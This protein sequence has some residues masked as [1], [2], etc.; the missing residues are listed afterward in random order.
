M[1]HAASESSDEG[2]QTGGADTSADVG[3]LDRRRQASGSN[4]AAEQQQQKKRRRRTS[5]ASHATPARMPEAAGV[6]PAASASHEPPG[7][8]YLH[9]LFALGRGALVLKHEE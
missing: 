7:E 2:E 4:G 9:S 8:N 1:A 3:S 6:S 5:D